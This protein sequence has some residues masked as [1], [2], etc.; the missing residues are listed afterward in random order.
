MISSSVYHSCLVHALST[1]REEIM[2]ILMGQT[3]VDGDAHVWHSIIIPRLDKRPDRVEI[4]SERLVQAPENAL[5]FS[6]ET[7]VHT[8]VLGW[9]H[10]HPHITPYP[11]HVDL[12]TQAI[13]QLIDPVWVGLIFS[14]F[15]QKQ[16]QQPQQIIVS[17]S[18]AA[19]TP[20]SSNSQQRQHTGRVALHCFQ[21]NVPPNNSGPPT[22]RRV[23][24]T[25]VPDEFFFSPTA[26]LAKRNNLLLSSSVVTPS[27]TIVS[28][29]YEM[30]D[31]I[32]A[33]IEE[34]IT[35]SNFKKQY[36]EEKF[37]KVL[38]EEA[39]KNV[40]ET[41][42]FSVCQKLLRPLLVSSSQNNEGSSVSA[43]CQIFHSIEQ[44]QIEEMKR[45]EEILAQLR[46]EVK[47]LKEASA[48]KVLQGD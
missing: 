21:S 32:A 6:Q 45:N 23:P 36:S 35:K 27:R 46:E 15:D 28:E 48:L 44:D 1:E 12:R 11:S 4:S 33:E 18:I 38:Y 5:K 16:H 30:R 37:D 13:Y 47:H 17:N 24:V 8:R 31:T 34:E 3:T 39:C 9:Y 29:S 7:G 20:T 26:L 22:H 42:T 41:Q 10:S 43:S 25:V 2:G 40:I 19:T 14:V